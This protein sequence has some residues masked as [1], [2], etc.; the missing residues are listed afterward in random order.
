MEE[1]TTDTN[2]TP[3]RYLA[4]KRVMRASNHFMS[5]LARMGVSVRGAHRLLVRGRTSGQWRSVPV[6]LLDFE[7]GHYLVAPRGNTEWARNLRAAGEGRLQLGCARHFDAVEVA[8]ADKAGIL[9]AYLE[10]W[11]SEVGRFF[12]GIEPDATDAD[13]A[14]VAADYPVFRLTFR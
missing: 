8:D 6:N 14:A 2:S 11:R 3:G 1:T 10:R 13:L 5:G 9:R 12:P 7:G 4:P